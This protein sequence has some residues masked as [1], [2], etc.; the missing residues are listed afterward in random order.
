MQRG[1]VGFPGRQSLPRGALGYLLCTV[2]IDKRRIATAISNNAFNP[3]VKA[4]ARAGIRLPGVVL[5]ETT[6]RKTLKPRRTPVGAQ[7]EGDSL[8]I[9][10]EHGRRADY[11]RNIE[12]NPRV[13]V[14]IGRRWRTGTGQTLPDDD[15]RERLRK[16]SR[17]KLGLRLNTLGVRTMASDPLTVRIDLDPT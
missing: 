14:K 13:S 6:G 17:A 3:F 16:M 4:G 1:S 8:W 12:A 11:V 15:P 2:R 9:V 7:V 5:L 10:A